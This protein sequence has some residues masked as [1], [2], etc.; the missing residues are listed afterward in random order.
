MKKNQKK[1]KKFNRK[2]PLLLLVLFLFVTA[3]GFSSYLD[4]ENLKL[5]GELHSLASS[6]EWLKYEINDKVSLNQVEEYAKNNLQMSEPTDAQIQGVGVDLEK[7][8]APLVKDDEGLK[9]GWLAKMQKTVGDIF[10][11][12]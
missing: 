3:R 4:Q 7:I 5:Q 11:G 8:Q 1:G 6:N 2:I 9:T 12:K 10:N